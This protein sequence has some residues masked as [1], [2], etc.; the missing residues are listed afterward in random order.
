[1]LAQ[2]S[3][4][5]DIEGFKF[6]K[7][8]FVIKELSIT[9]DYTDTILFSPPEPLSNLQKDHQYSVCWLSRNLHGLS[10]DSGEYPYNLLHQIFLSIS[11]RYPAHTF[12]AKGSEKCEFLSHN[13]KCNVINLETLNCPKIEDLIEATTQQPC[14]NHSR[15]LS[16]YQRRKHCARLKSKLFYNWLLSNDRSGKNTEFTNNTTDVIASFRKLD[17]D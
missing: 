6:K 16:S 3:V 15:K 7:S 1:M 10:W 4:V 12:Y 14:R 11:L 17:L 9:G 2:K 13:L 5:L 8:T